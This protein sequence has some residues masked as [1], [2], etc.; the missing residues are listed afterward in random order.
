[1]GKIIALGG[2][3]RSGKTELARICEKYGYE[4]L[5]FALPLKQLC[6][7][8]LDISIEELNKI[9][10][11]HIKIEITIN[12]DICKIL[13]QETNIP[14][15]TTMTLCKGKYLHTVRDM[16]QFIGTDYIRNCNEN[17]HVDRIKQLIDENKNYVFDDVRFQNEKQMIEELGGDVWFIT[18]TTLDNISNHE[19]ETSISWKQCWNRI[20]INNS[21]L[22]NL[23][24]RWEIFIS[25]YQDSMKQREIEFNK[26][27]NNEININDISP[28]SILD[29]LFISKDM[30]T[31]TPKDFSVNKIKSAKMNEDKSV[32]VT[33]DDDTIELI[34]N[35]LIIEDLKLFL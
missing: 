3:A 14:L 33:Y 23:L 22:P 26:I 20:I 4:K 13:S 32:F 30:F 25:N 15:E 6:A 5:Y 16:L 18:R 10:N 2:R 21:T 8:I 7:D 29:M 35:P 17:W 28:L 12:E 27:L 1:M 19:S 34:D 24:F 11:N 9:K 31:Y